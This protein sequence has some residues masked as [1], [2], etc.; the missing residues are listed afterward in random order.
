VLMAGISQTAAAAV[1]LIAAVAGHLDTLAL[2]W[3]FARAVM[4]GGSVDS[5]AAFKTAIAAYTGDRVTVCF[6][7]ASVVSE[8][9]VPGA[10]VLEVP[11]AHAVAERA[12]GTDLSENL[13]RSL[14]GTLRG[15]V[16]VSHDERF[17]LGFTEADRIVTLTSI[18][19]EGGFFVTNGYIRSAQSSDFKY[20]DWGCL[21]DEAC[22][23]LHDAL[24]MWRLENLDAKTDGSGNLADV[25]AGLVEKSAQLALN[26]RIMQPMSKSGRRGYATAAQ[27]RI[28]RTNDFF[29]TGRVQGTC[30]LMARRPA[31]TF[32]IQIGLVRQITA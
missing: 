30:A 32:S 8:S 25:D 2:H 9:A 12:A 15:V 23:V 13:G 27:F 14:S 3:H 17:E 29:G 28:D 22:E 10:D 6:G 21:T 16:R 20:F 24:L 18:E 26:A 19:N 5:L 4:D 31:E 1:T 11:I 7:R